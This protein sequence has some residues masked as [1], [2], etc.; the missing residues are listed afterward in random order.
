MSTNIIKSKEGEENNS[1]S[2]SKEVLNEPETSSERSS[3][4]KR[5]LSPLVDENGFKLRRVHV[6][7]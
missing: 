6:D 7:A 3:S 2:D 5:G 4:Y 1:N